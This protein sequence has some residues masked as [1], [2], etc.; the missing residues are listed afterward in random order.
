MSPFKRKSYSN[1]IIFDILKLQDAEDKGGITNT[2]IRKKEI[3]LK[4]YYLF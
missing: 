1:E 2:F 4:K 3:S